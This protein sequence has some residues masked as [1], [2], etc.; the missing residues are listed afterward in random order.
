MFPE[1]D[2][3]LPLNISMFQK[4]SPKGMCVKCLGNGGI[5]KAYEE[6]I[7]TDNTVKLYDLFEGE[8]N[9]IKH[10]LWKFQKATGVTPDT[11]KRDG[12]R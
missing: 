7:F 2:D 3:G 5:F 6:E 8:Q 4:N 1:Y 10:I 12:V 9:H 11:R